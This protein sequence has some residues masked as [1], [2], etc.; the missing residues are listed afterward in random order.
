VK[1]VGK[2]KRGLKKGISTVILYL[3]FLVFLPILL[4]VE[5]STKEDEEEL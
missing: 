3:A 1:K 2:V 5:L 4:I